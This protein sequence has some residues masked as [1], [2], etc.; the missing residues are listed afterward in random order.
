MLKKSKLTYKIL[1]FLVF[2]VEAFIALFVRDDFVR[3]Y[4]G[5]VLVT[6]LICL[7][8]RAFFP[9]KTNLLPVY[10]FVF[11]VAIETGQY[12]DI[13]K[14]LGFENSAI[15]STVLGRTFS[16]A[17][18]VCYGVGCAVFSVVEQIVLKKFKIKLVQIKY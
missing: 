2:A 11:A 15:I 4:V 17:D 7:F 14:L 18:L 12:F 3:P 13:V 8:F 16:V 1:F 9:I 10:V 6:V 5:D